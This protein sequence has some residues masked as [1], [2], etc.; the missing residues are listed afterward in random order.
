MWQ[1]IIKGGKSIW[2]KPKIQAKIHAIMSDGKK[3][4][5]EQIFLEG[6]KTNKYFPEARSFAQWMKSKSGGNYNFDTVYNSEKRNEE[7]VY[8]KGE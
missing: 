3:R 7:T 8:W 2:N 5:G 1:D 4:N 6:R